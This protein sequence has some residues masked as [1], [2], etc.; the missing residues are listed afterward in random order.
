MSQKNITHIKYTS[1]RG[2][3]T[4][5]SDSTAFPKQTY[6]FECNSIPQLCNFFPME[7]RA[8]KTDI[9]YGLLFYLSCNISLLLCVQPFPITDQLT[10]Y[11]LTHRTDPPCVNNYSPHNSQ[12]KQRSVLCGALYLTVACLQ[13]VLTSDTI[14]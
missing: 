8:P 3:T 7:V 4:H 2:S 6:F 9:I 11:S 13:Q 1:Q 5:Q 10:N 14:V 12:S